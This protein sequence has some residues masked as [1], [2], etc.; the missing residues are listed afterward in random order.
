MNAKTQLK[1]IKDF[2]KETIDL[3]KTKGADYGNTDVLSNF[4]QVS[5][6]CK[7]LKIDTT[8]PEGYAIFMVV[9]KI[10]RIC[11][12]KA[13]NKTPNNE[14]LLDSYRDLTNYTKLASLCE[15]ETSTEKLAQDDQNI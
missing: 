8:T 6:V 4:K 7:V 13:G 11:N 1:L 3:I 10:A 15:L 14:S 2:D 5:E 12:L 9:L